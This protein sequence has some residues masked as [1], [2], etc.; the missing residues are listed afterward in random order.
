LLDP[1]FDNN[2][3]ICPLVSVDLCAFCIAAKTLLELKGVKYIF[4][5]VSYPGRQEPIFTTL[6]DG[7]SLIVGSIGTISGVN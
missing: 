1:S 5:A 3:L 4:S 6:A 2:K 7:P